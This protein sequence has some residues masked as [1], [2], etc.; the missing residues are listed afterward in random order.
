MSQFVNGI[1]VPIGATSTRNATALLPGL[2]L[3]TADVACIWRQG[4]LN[5]VAEV[6]IPGNGFL[7]GGVIVT[8]KNPQ[9]G[10]I[11]VLQHTTAGNL[12]IQQLLR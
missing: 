4:D 11:A 2:Y 7:Q 10:F 9:R 12:Y 8:V 5:V 6:G 3:V 1:V